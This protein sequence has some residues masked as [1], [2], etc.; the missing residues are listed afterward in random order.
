VR[1]G[2]MGILTEQDKQAIAEEIKKAESGTSGEIVFAI[3]DSSARYHH[4]TL[5]AALLGMILGTAVYLALPVEHAIGMVLWTQL[6]FFTLVYA[7]V[8]HLSW[9]RI[10]IPP[11]ELD[12]RVREAAFVEFYSSGLYRTAES[13]GVLIY[14]SVLER[15][16]V[17]LGDKGIHERMGDRHWDDVRDRIILGIHQGRAREGVIESIA[18]CGK[19]LAEHF[20]HRPDD[21]NELPDGVIERKLRPD[22]P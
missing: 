10:M 14:L 8:P 7:L 20:P 13:N 1:R 11:T 3:A 2:A 18:I 6:V 4:A 19:A 12:A 21:V 15:R 5:Q 16:V 22:A 17:V 9:R